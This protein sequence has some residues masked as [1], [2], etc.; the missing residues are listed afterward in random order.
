MPRQPDFI[1]QGTLQ[2]TPAQGREG[3]R[4]CIR[5]LVTWG[6]PAADP[7]RDIT[8]R[9]GLNIIRSPD[10]S[11][12]AEASL[13]REAM[14]HGGGK[15][16]FRRLLRYCLGEPRFASEDQRHR[17]AEVFLMA[18][19][20]PRS[21]S[22]AGRGRSSGRLPPSQPRFQY[23]VTT[24]TKP[25]IALAAATV[26]ELELKGFPSDQRLLRCDL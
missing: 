23:I 5:R 9:P 20:A 8:L 2:I 4:L 19:S 13:I 24:T 3:P 12:Q 11:E 25:P 1:S 10:G 17:I 16:L 18:Q 7:I 22:K 14:G 15:T 26:T 21:F 6:D